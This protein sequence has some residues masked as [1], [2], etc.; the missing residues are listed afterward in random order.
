MARLKVAAVAAAAVA[1]VMIGPPRIAHAETNYWFVSPSGNIG[2]VMGDLLHG[3]V[4][5][6]I[7]QYTYPRPPDPNNCTGRTTWGNRFSLNP[8]QAPQM[9]C[10]G[11]TVFDSTRDKTLDYGQKQS[12]GPITCASEPTGM[13]CTD[14]GTGHYFRVSTE[15]YE[16]H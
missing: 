10:H 9:P 3:G 15:S 16:L 12:F 4:T 2:C 6:D 11:D 1:A 14:T 13:T 7:K 5:C 8:G